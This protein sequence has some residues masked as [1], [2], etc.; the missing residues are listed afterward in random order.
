MI[1]AVQK[2]E[3]W[4]GTR[5]CVEKAGLYIHIKERLDFYKVD[6]KGLIEKVII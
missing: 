3:A 2:S 1:S 4:K 6:R 5:E